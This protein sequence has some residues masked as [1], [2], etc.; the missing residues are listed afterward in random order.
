MEEEAV[1]VAVE[2]EEGTTVDGRRT[3]QEVHR[4]GKV[5]AIRHHLILMGNCAAFVNNG[6]LEAKAKAKRSALKL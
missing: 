3:R 5:A 2:A 6:D 1:E 4:I